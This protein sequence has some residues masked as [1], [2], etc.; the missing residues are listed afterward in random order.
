MTVLTG[1]DALLQN[2]FR[3][4]AGRRIGLLTNPS[5]VDRQLSSTYDIFRRATEVNLTAIFTPEHGFAAAAPDAAHIDSTIDRRTGL[6]VYSLYGQTYRPTA[7]MLAAVDVIVCDIQDIGVRYYTYA[8]TITHIL[9]AAGEAGVEVMILDRPNP[10]GGITIAGPPVEPGFE[11]LVGRFSVPIQPG[12]TLGELAQLV[13][14]TWNPTPAALTVVRCENWRR[15]YTWEQT[16]LPWTPTSPAMPHCA[17]VRQYPGAC[18]VEGTNLSDGRGTALP[19][20]IVGAPWIDAPALAD[21]L[22]AQG[23]TGVRFRPHTFL[24]T[25]SKWRDQTCCGVQAHITAPDRWQPIAV[26][27]GVIRAIRRLYPDQFHW[28]PP[29]SGGVEAGTVHHFDRLIG[30]DQVRQQIE[31]GVPLAEITANWDDFVRAFAEKRQPFLLYD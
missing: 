6:L 17:T 16:G 29:E 25:T 26:W 1:I 3:W 10:L 23:W 7:E 27:L 15:A 31:A 30:S 2:G 20:E 13:N 12:L 24:P 28:L 9:E 5:G 18:L 14:A 11:S 21:H 22:N 4:L 8:W 19:F